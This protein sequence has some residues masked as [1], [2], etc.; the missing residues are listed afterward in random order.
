MESIKLK[1]S[2]IYYYGS[3]SGYLKDSTANIDTLFQCEELTNWCK[4]KKFEPCFSDGIFE[5]LARKEDV[6]QFMKNEE[7]LKNVRIWQLK[8][9][10]DFSM[11]FI[12]FDEFKEKFGEPSKDNFEV[13]FDGSLPTN[14]IDAIYEICNINHPDGYKGHSLS[15]SDVVELYDESGSEFHYVDQFGFR[16]VDFEAQEQTQ[17]FDMKM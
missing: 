3:P 8:A 10:S 11:R 6:S 12:S 13:V 15:M 17:A 7:T 16:E 2:L 1:N 5:A 4:E 14:N 9:D